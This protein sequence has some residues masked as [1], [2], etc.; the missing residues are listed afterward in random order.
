VRR[1]ASLAAPVA[2]LVLLT[3]CEGAYDLPLPG[4]ADTG[5]HPYRV[6]VEL[7]DVLD[8]V[9]RSAVK[10][11]DVPV[12]EVERI[13]RDGWTAQVVLRLAGDVHLPDNAVATLRQTSLLGEKFVSLAAPADEADQAPVGRLADGDVIPLARSSRTAEVEEVLGAM[14]LLLNGGGVAQLQ[15]INREL[16]AALEG[17][18]ADVRGALRQLDVFVSGLDE[19]KGE[20]VRAIEAVDALAAT[21]ARQQ[22][23]LEV[24]LAEIP[25]GLEVLADQREQLTGMLTALSELGVTASRVINASQDDLVANL[26]ALDPVLSRLVEAGDALPKSLELLLTY[27]FADSVVEGMRGDYTNLKVTAEVDV[28]ALRGLLP[29]GLPRL[30][31]VPAEP[32]PSPARTPAPG[33]PVELPTLDDVCGSLGLDRGCGIG[34]PRTDLGRLLLGGLS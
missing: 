6:T 12:G 7:T 28:E 5:A 22:R 16:N 34:E 15:L 9:P 29:T 23:D 25:A 20:I 3:G 30:P 27:P 24:A 4:G 33:R 10:V 14:S 21:L 26:A 1:L 31:A 17:R 2:A 13:R 19:Q 11:N 8:L 32:A 18:E